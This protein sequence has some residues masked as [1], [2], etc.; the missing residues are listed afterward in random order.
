[1]AQWQA[2]DYAKVKAA[3]AAFVE[4]CAKSFQENLDVLLSP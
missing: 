2:D 3:S 1:L 4:A